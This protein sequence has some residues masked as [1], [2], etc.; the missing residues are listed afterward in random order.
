VA[1]ALDVTDR[2]AC[3]ALA[4]RIG[5][6]YGRT[7]VLVNNAGI[8]P[9]NTIDDPQALELW[10]RTIDVNLRGAL[11]V[12]MAFLPALRETKG[13][14]V[15][16]TSI[17]AYVSTQ[18]SLGYSTSKA[19][20]MMLTRTLAQ[21]L[22]G[23]GIR[24]NAIAPGP[25]ETPMT[26]VTRNDPVRFSRFV[27]RIPMGR[28]GQPDELVG[29]ALFLASDLSSYVTGATIIVDGGYLLG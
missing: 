24:V 20:L 6:T 10:D 9:R 11:N 13:R 18:T 25:F 8:C 28:F 27:D 23:E 3:E 19:G 4:A 15:N 22:A 1:F 26:E 21:E 16:I 12:V 7:S 17:S 14:V 29:P 5:D 2:A